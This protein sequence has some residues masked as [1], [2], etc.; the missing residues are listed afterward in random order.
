MASRSGLLKTL[1]VILISV[2]AVAYVVVPS[3]SASPQKVR[4]TVLMSNAGDPY[5]SNKSYGYQQYANQDP[6]IDLE[7]F[8]AGG[9][10]KL[11]VQVSQIENA[12]QRGVDV[13]LV[14][15]VDA[16]GVCP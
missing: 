1:V 13:L 9:Y 14:T 8:N 12:V 6:G 4:V 15:P 2:A 3:H 5:F 10:D 16:K 7:Y 11:E